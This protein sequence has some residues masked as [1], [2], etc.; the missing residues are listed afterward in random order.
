[1]VAVIAN[2]IVHYYWHASIA[3]IGCLVHVGGQRDQ[4]A[5]TTHTQQNKAE[6]ALLTE[7]VLATVVC[8][9]KMP[10]A[11]PSHS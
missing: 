3:S 2:I 6:V 4:H 11:S 9:T 5:H 7:H 10:L 1:M 8:G